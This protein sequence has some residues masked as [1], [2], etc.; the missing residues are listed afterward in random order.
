MSD[1]T[2]LQNSFATGYL[3]PLLYGLFTS[4]AYSTGLKECYNYLPSSRGYLY[5]RPGTRYLDFPLSSDAS[6][7]RLYVMNSDNGPLLFLISEGRIDFFSTDL[8]RSI[9]ITNETPYSKV[10]GENLYSDIPWKK[11]ELTDLNIY[12]FEGDI[13][14][15]HQYYPPHKITVVARGTFE[16]TETK[17]A[18]STYDIPEEVGCPELYLKDA[19]VA[20]AFYC[21]PIEFKKGG[22]ETF[23]EGGHYPSCQT[24]KGGRWYLSGCTDSPASI[25]ASKAPDAYGSYRFDDF[26][27]GNYYL[28]HVAVLMRKITIYETTEADG[29]VLSVNYTSDTTTNENVKVDG[30]DT[31][32]PDTKSTTAYKRYSTTTE[33]TST[34]VGTWTG[35]D[36][37]SVE[38]KLATKMTIV[39]TISDTWTLKSDLQNDDAIELTETDMYG[40]KVNWLITQQRVIAGTNRSIWMDDGSA[41]TPSTFD[42]VKTLGVTTSK[43]TPI[44]YSSMIIFVPADRR[45]LKAF[46][47]DTDAEGYVLSDLSAT[48]KSLFRSAIIKDI[49]LVEGS[50]TIIWILLEN[51][52]LLSCTMGATYGWAEH[53]LGG[54]GKIISMSAYHTDDNE[55]Q[56]YLTV[57]RGEKITVESLVM[58]D[59]VNTDAYTLCDCMIPLTAD[60]DDTSYDMSKLT[61]SGEQPYPTGSEVCIVSGGWSQQSFS[62]DPTESQHDIGPG[63][64]S[65]MY[66]GYPYTSRCQMLWQELPVS[67][68]QTSLGFFR[69]ALSM[70]LQV[71]RSA[72]AECGWTSGGKKHLDPFQKLA[73]TNAAE[74]TYADYYTGIVKL[75]VPSNTDEQVN[76]VIECSYPLPMTIQA[77]ETRYKLQEV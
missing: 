72:G 39:E 21:T 18:D 44:I 14:A 9:T 16:L 76:A 71:Y 7:N 26:G 40:S 15:V 70:V 57:Q 68:G 45:S 23:S 8:M 65:G 60:E 67:S 29:A 77:I 12:E 56:L 42:L 3:D 75:S 41:A 13:Y 34:L 48:A 38:Q 55:G 11:K 62:Y 25:Y 17:Y 46:N 24:F 58:E 69:K 32:V 20:N 35:T 37:A 63:S 19:Y 47:Y 53:E 59:I 36:G 54:D 22:I 64:K 5:R 28:L 1:Y 52:R 50:E 27:V 51:G 31:E 74:P 6:E 43:I 10:D 49:A 30:L 33:D 2:R 66:I 4:D 61:D 73:K